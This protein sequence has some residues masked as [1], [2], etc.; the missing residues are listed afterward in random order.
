MSSATGSSNLSSNNIG[1]LAKDEQARTRSTPSGPAR[2]NHHDD[3]ARARRESPPARTKEKGRITVNRLWL[4]WAKPLMG[5]HR[6][7][8][9]YAAELRVMLDALT[10]CRGGCLSER[11]DGRPQLLHFVHPLARL[12]QRL[13][14]RRGNVFPHKVASVLQGNECGLLVEALRGKAGQAVVVRE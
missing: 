3:L 10:L 5:Y 4:L 14:N 11:R 13:L 6:E 8:V 9:L 2:Q 12:Q 7:D 1:V